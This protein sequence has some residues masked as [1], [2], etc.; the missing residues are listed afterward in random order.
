MKAQLFLGFV[1]TALAHPAL[2]IPVI[3]SVTPNKGPVGSTVVIAG[4]DFG[5]TPAE[6][7]VTFGTIR[8]EITAA[9]TTALSVRVP[10][11]ATF[12]PITVNHA[13]LIAYS[14]G[15]FVP[16]FLSNRQLST[17]SFTAPI[18][19]PSLQT[20]HGILGD[21]D[22]D[23]KVD[24]VFANY[25]SD[26]L[27]VFR[28]INQGTDLSQNS[29]DTRIDFPTGSGPQSLAMGDLDG[30]GQ[31]EIAV[32]ND[33][34]QTVSVF[35]N[36]SSPGSF[37]VDS[38]AEPVNVP[39]GY[40]PVAVAISDMDGDGKPD[41]VV[42]N[43]VLGPSTVSVHRNIST[44]GSI[45]A[46]S[47]APGVHFQTDN[48]SFRLAVGDLDGD[49]KP[50]IVVANVDSSIL[51]ILHNTS[52]PGEI[53]EGSFAPAISLTLPAHPYDVALADFDGDG[54]LDIAANGPFDNSFVLR[55]LS[56]P[57]ELNASSFAQPLQVT[58]GGT[59][60]R[61]AD[62]D[63]DGRPDIIVSA[64]SIGGR[65]LAFHV[66]QSTPGT[67]QFAAPITVP[68]GGERFDV[69]DLNG[70]GTPD[71]VTGRD[72]VGGSGIFLIQNI[73]PHPD[74]RTP[75]VYY[76]F[77]GNARDLSSSSLHGTV[78]GATLVPD[79]F[80]NDNNAFE[81][82][83]GPGHIELPKLQLS[84]DISISGWFSLAGDPATNGVTLLGQGA[85]GTQRWF[86]SATRDS[87]AWFD[88]RAPGEDN[89]P[90]RIPV[91]LQPGT[92]HHVVALVSSSFPQGQKARIYLDGALA[93]AVSSRAFEEIDAGY[94][95]GRLR[96]P[97]GWLYSQGQVDDLRVYGFLL[98]ESA[99]QLL[100]QEIIGGNVCPLLVT[101]PAPQLLDP[102]APLTLSITA[103]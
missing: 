49:G 11:A 28:N 55:N 62:L 80:G 40:H 26:V 95:V 3:H 48:H 68:G 7:I 100:H 92:W 32:P 85:S 97:G 87:L 51:N 71:L 27:S 38:L 103:L 10:V 47:F 13:G 18:M 75:L 72:R 8:A 31:M 21:V 50:D 14:P 65:M 57:G 63:G 93:G 30:D 66:N 19:L 58:G 4:E 89:A 59:E 24:I 78:V 52:V 61:V 43:A 54:K 42:A 35:R 77:A 20:P 98:D 16:T 96:T 9:S 5:A 39:A 45:D 101:G 15:P 67:L 6:N 60:I 29:F 88:Q 76:P 74:W 1:L 46:N 34:G 94:D 25:H 73:I 53:T 79:R 33:F 82:N 44:L 99:I 2:A 84:G 23:G 36:L 81:F 22:G 86:L 69:A 12:Q 41:L 70:D 37:T 102:G 90:Y 91:S 64:S 83:G 56:Q 17:D